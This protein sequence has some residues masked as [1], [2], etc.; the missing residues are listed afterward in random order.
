MH[1][2]LSVELWDLAALCRVSGFLEGIKLVF[3]IWMIMGS[4]RFLLILGALPMGVFWEQDP[5]VALPQ[6]GSL[7]VW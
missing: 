4:L 6:S 1:V 5:E 7:T 2:F 3:N